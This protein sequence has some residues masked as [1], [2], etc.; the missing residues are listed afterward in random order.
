MKGKNFCLQGGQEHLDLKLSQ[1]QRFGSPLLYV[2][3]K[4]ASKNHSGGLAQ[5]RVKNKVVLIVDVPE[6]GPRCHVSTNYHQKLLRKMQNHI[7]LL[8][9]LK[10]G[11]QHILLVRTHSATSW[12][13]C[14]E[15]EVNG[16]K[17]NHSLRATGVCN[18]FQAGVP[19]KLIQQRSGH[20]SLEG[21]RQYQRTTLDPEKAVSR[22]LK[23]KPDRNRR[24]WQCCQIY[25]FI[26]NILIFLGS[27][28]LRIDFEE[29]SKSTDNLSHAIESGFVQCLLCEWL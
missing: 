3:I 13:M 10:C 21:L 12:N 14:K 24:V 16:K 4:N 6:A 15:G 23:G 25:W 17:T 9:I 22:L 8:L 7:R 29:M 11:L 2:Y 1:F 20:H 5:I 28:F 18:L 19:E 27:Q 26:Q